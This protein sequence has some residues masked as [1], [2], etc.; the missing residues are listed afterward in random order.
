VPLDQIDLSDP[1]LW[2]G[3]R[4]HREDVFATLRTHA[5]VRFFAERDIPMLPAGP[6]YWAVTRHEDVWAASRNPALFKSGNGTNIPDYP[7][8]IAEFMGSIINMDDPKPPV[9]RVQGLHPEGGR[10]HRG[11]RP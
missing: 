9:D 1:E 6:G 8:G 11:L 7:P 3:D 10:P 4:D 2:S 5:P